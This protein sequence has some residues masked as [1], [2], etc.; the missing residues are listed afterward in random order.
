MPA[1]EKDFTRTFESGRRSIK[2][3]KE[4]LIITLYSCLCAAYNQ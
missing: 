4:V 3:K 1:E 2:A